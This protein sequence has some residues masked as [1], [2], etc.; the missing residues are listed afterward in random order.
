MQRR[1]GATRATV[2]VRYV[3]SVC[4]QCSMMHGERD[5]GW[6]ALVRLDLD[7]A[8]PLRSRIFDRLRRF[9]ATTGGLA[10][11]AASAPRKRHD[12]SEDHV[13]D[14]DANEGDD[15]GAAARNQAAID[16]RVQSPSSLHSVHRPIG[17]K[18]GPVEWRLAL[19]PHLQ[20]RLSDRI[21]IVIAILQK[22]TIKAGD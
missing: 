16:T 3:C 10:S 18:W 19:S 6:A 1:R 4:R 17:N 13:P 8:H 22:V 21:G 9:A 14:R 11:T 20:C 2:S 12:A 15:R 7:F 5:Q